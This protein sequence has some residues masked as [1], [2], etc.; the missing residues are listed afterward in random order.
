MQNFVNIFLLQGETVVPTLHYRQPENNGMLSVV[1]HSEKWF[2]SLKCA[3]DQ[4]IS[5]RFAVVFHIVCNIE[6]VIEQVIRSL[7]DAMCSSP[8]FDH[9]LAVSGQF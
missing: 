1:F 2:R 5:K 3:C 6:P 8:K 7:F 4:R 9:I